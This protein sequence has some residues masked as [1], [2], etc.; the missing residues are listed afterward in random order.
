MPVIFEEALNTE[1]SKGNIVRVYLLF[2]DDPYLKKFYAD[3]ISEK[4]YDGDPF[5]NF[6]KFEGDVELQQVYDAVV[7]LPMMAD[8]KCVVLN[9]FDY[10]H[11]SKSE[12]DKLCTL[13]SETNDEC[14][15]ILRFDSVEFDYKRGNKAKKLV[16]AA[17]K[18]GGRAV[19]LDHRKPAQLVKMLTDGAA[20]RKC[21]MDSVVAR[22]VI[23]TVGDDI[24]TLKN[25]LDKLCS[26]VSDGVIDKATVDRVCIKSVESS[27]YDYMKQVLACNLEEAL[28]L[29]DGL[30]FMRIEPMII[31]HTAA[32]SYIDLYRV[33]VAKKSGVGIPQIARDFGYKNRAFVL[34]RAAVDLK[35]MDSK[36]I[37]LGFEALLDA[38]K[39]LK[40]SGLDP[41]VVLEQ[42]TVRLV[43]II[44]KGESVD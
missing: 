34:E 13:L 24:S 15:L 33:H 3:K 40:S 37:T 10:E 27:V 32:S 8:R 44:I 43:Y 9:D 29:L 20:K 7:Q 11:A 42:L 36:R 12:F 5:F 18:G 4:S 35:K 30:F 39:G 19:C 28:R 25:E 16:A 38:E 17:E 26:F 41:R 31:L 22:Y 23:E 2:G 14:V 21:R 6:C 1:L